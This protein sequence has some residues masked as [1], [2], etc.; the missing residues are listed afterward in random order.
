MG[1]SGACFMKGFIR[2]TRTTLKHGFAAILEI[3]VLN[4]IIARLQLLYEIQRADI[5]Q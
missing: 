2:K 5:L 3:R 1:V 4:P